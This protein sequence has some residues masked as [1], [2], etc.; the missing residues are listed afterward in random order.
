MRLTHSA[1]QK[2]QDGAGSNQTD[3]GVVIYIITTDSMAVLTRIKTS[4]LPD[5]WHMDG[6]EGVW[7]RITFMHVPGITGVAIN[8]TADSL[9][10]VC[11]THVPL[12]LCLALKY[13][14]YDASR[15]SL[16]SGDTRY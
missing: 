4:W 9:A 6:N 5:G 14:Q 1:H 3:I 13:I 11:K 10:S 15:Q 8:G 16:N 7:S 2:H 12:Q